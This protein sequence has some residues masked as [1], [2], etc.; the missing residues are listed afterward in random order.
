MR[1][2]LCI[3]LLAREICELHPDMLDDSH[4][5]MDSNTDEITL[6]AGDGGYVP[7]VTRLVERGFKVDVVFWNQAAKELKDCCSK[8]VSLNDRLGY[9]RFK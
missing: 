8:F 6:V 1:K 5:L 4:R 2:S 9:L 7:P 3:N